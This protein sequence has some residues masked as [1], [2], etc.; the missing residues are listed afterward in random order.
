LSNLVASAAVPPATILSLGAALLH[1]VWPPLGRAAMALAEPFAAWILWVA[2]RTGAATFAAI[3]VPRAAA[4]VAALPV[5]WW[6]VIAV[7]RRVG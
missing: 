7:R 2:E 4:L 6:T 1:S 5:G 3:E